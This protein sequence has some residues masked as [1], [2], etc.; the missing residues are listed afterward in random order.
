MLSTLAARCLRSLPRLRH[1]PH[2]PGQLLRAV[3]LRRRLVSAGRPD[4]RRQR[5]PLRHYIRRRDQWLR[6]G[7]RDRQDQP[8]LRHHPHHSGQL[9][10]RR[11]RS[12]ACRPDRR[13]QR[14][15]L[16]HDGAWRCE[17]RRHGVRD[18]REWLCR[19]PQFAGTPGKPN[20][21]GQSVSAL[22]RQYGGLNNAAAALGYPSVQALQK[23]ILEYCE[24]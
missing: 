6:H 9:Q 8:R 12:A 21:F 20:C 3:E 23:A 18:H 5:Q 10:R 17:S 19:P 15:P 1:R 16:W 2:H 4:P 22:A 11:W 24:G 14:Q 7:V 13:R